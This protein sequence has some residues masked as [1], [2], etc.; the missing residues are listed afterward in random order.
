MSS[1]EGTIELIARGLVKNR[2]GH[3]LLCKHNK[4]DY[5]YLPGG[6]VEPGERAAEALRREFMEE[7]GQRVA[8]GRLLACEEHLFRHKKSTRHEV[9]LVFHVELQTGAEA[10]R[11]IESHLSFEWVPRRLLESIDLRPASARDMCRLGNRGSSTRW[12]S[13]V[14]TTKRL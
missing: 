3:V 2:S 8:V 4:G 9:N 6:H 1:R 7:T 11:S 12:V 14:G 5:Y 13:S 10:V